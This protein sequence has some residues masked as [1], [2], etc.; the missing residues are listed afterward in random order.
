MLLYRYQNLTFFRGIA[1]LATVGVPLSRSGLSVLSCLVVTRHHDCTTDDRYQAIPIYSTCNLQLPARC[2]R[3]A[4]PSALVVLLF[5]PPATQKFP[6]LGFACFDF[7]ACRRG[8]R[9]TCCGPGDQLHLPGRQPQRT[10]HCR[11]FSRP[12][13]LLTIAGHSEC[14]VAVPLRFFELLSF[15]HLT[16]A[17]RGSSTEQPLLEP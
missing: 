3:C 13:L 1:W 11:C 12:R 4:P 9:S 17:R 5:F 8:P 10:N 15:Y 7:A 16:R 14:C 6:L 2:L